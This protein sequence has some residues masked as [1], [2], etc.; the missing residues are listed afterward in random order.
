MSPEPPGP[1]VFGVRIHSVR[2]STRYHSPANTTKYGRE[3]NP[4]LWLDDYRLHAELARWRGMISS[5]VTSLFTSQTRLEPSSC[6][7]L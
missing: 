5:S 3:T 6:I 7:F 4:S 1:R 2:V